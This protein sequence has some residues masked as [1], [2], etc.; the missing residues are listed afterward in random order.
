M[1]EIYKITMSYILIIVLILSGSVTFLSIKPVDAKCIDWDGSGKCVR[2]ND[3]TAPTSVKGRCITEW[4]A[5]LGKMVPCGGSSDGRKHP[6]GFSPSANMKKVCQ[7]QFGS[8]YV[9]YSG[10]TNTCMTLSQACQ[11]AVAGTTRWDPV[12]QKCVQ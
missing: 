8:E 2:Y 9:S 5:T 10:R 11:Y 4:D 3:P 7:K 6:S 1:W 12:K